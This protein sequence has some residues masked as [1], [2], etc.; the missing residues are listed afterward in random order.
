MTVKEALTVKGRHL[1]RSVSTPNV[2]HV[3]IICPDL[4]VLKP[5]ANYHSVMCSA[6]QSSCS[7]MDLTG[8]EDEDCKVRG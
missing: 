3:M 2:Q 7:K 1:R 6:V 4:T 5:A 8:C